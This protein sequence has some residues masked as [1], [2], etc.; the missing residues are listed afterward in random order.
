MYGNLS[1]WISLFYQFHFAVS[2]IHPSKCRWFQQHP[3]KL[4][5]HLR[6]LLLISW[7]SESI[8]N[9]F[10][11]LLKSAVVCGWVAST[12]KCSLHFAVVDCH[13]YISFKVNL[14]ISSN[15]HRPGQWVPLEYA[16]LIITKYTQLSLPSQV[17]NSPV[18]SNILTK[19][20]KSASAE[21]WMCSFYT[22]IELCLSTTFHHL[23]LTRYIYIVQ[24]T[25]L[26]IWCITSRKK[27]G[28]V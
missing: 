6:P 7:D 11:V 25:Y 24:Y 19:C 12:L 15:K 23:G 13:Y 22:W 26:Q 17:D 10:R 14:V 21:T 3:R 20:V 27:S 18:W 1:V 2:W 8:G 5:H 16:L 28:L 9:S 4:L